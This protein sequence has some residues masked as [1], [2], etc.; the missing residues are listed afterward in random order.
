MKWSYLMF[1][2]SY[3]HRFFLSN[4][5]RNLQR[6]PNEICARLESP[7]CSCFGLNSQGENLFFFKA[8]VS[9]YPEKLGRLTGDKDGSSTFCR[10][11]HFRSLWFKDSVWFPVHSLNGTACSLLFLP[12]PLYVAIAV[13][14]SSNVSGILGNKRW[15]RYIWKRFSSSTVR[16]FCWNVGT[17]NRR[18]FQAGKE[19]IVFHLPPFFFVS[20]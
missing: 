14:T 5:W 9:K 2:I 4:L 10:L 19:R 3:D 18:V 20:N 16:V 11:I 1:N 17:G 12:A 15:H 6:E 13:R 8:P 7:P